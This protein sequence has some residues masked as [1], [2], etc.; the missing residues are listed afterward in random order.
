M[1]NLIYFDNAATTFPKPSS[2]TAAVT[3]AVTHYCANPG[4]S[5]HRLALRA[6]EQVY[7]CRERLARSFSCEPEN[8]VFSL[9]ATHAINTA[10]KSVLKKG[11]HVLISDIEHNAVFRPIAALA[12]RGFI[13]YDIYN[14]TAPSIIEELSAKIKPSTSLICA[15]HHSNICNLVLPISKIGAFCKNKNIFFLVDASQSAGIIPINMRSQ[16]IDILCAPAHKGLY[17]IPGCGFALFSEKAAKEGVLS[18][19]VEGGN[20][21]SSSSPFMP[22]FLPERLEAGTLPLPAIA[23]LCAGL[24]LV[25]KLGCENI[26]QKEKALCSLMRRGLSGIQGIKIHSKADGSI[27]LFSAKN[28]PSEKF[29]ALLDSG[30]IC[31]RAGLHCAPLAHKKLRTPENDGAVRVSF[32]ISN[33]EEEVRY[34]TALCRNIMQQSKR[35]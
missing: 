26:R 18:T 1:K 20:G 16:S 9:S 23:S 21:V 15:C 12:E 32:G 31:V 14:C 22:E 10:L 35:G 29:A 4:R 25:N 13:S 24:E 5:S 17:G 11:D 3:D 2:V 33:T 19:F 6:A 28:I 30:G 27:M 8:A 34:F 7:L